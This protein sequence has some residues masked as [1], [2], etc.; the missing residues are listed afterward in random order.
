MN[1][2]LISR[3]AA[4]AAFDN[5]ACE[6]SPREAMDE[7]QALPAVDA[8]P[9]RHGKW[10]NIKRPGSSLWCSECKAPSPWAAYH[11]F[12]PNCGAEME[13]PEVKD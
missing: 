11:N 13:K 5:Y 12:C 9:V 10:E 2:D 6:I 4:C 3:A 8:K 7:I 1:D